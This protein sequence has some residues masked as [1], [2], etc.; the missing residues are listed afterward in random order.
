MTPSVFLIHPPES[1]RLLLPMDARKVA[2][3]GV[4]PPLGILYLA[5]YLNAH[6]DAR[7]DILDA[8]GAG[9]D[10][11]TTVAEV[12][13]RKPS[14][15]GITC[16]TD[17][18]YDICALIQGIK[19][20]SP[21]SHIV[22]G[23]PHL[24]IFARQTLQHPLVDSIVVGD[25]EA[26]LAHLI[27]RLS[28]QT[29][30]PHPGLY[31]KGE[32]TVR[33]DFPVYVEKDLDRLP[34]PE[35]S[36]LPHIYSSAFS[37]GR[38][39][40]MVTSRGCP[41]RCTFCKLNFQKTLLRSARNVVDEMKVIA[42][43]G[44]DEIEIYDDTFGI[45]RDRVLEICHLMRDEGMRFKLT[46][47][48]RAPNLD[49]EVIAA[50]RSV[51]LQRVYLGVETASDA[52][53]KRIRKALKIE[54]VRS[55]V[56]SCKRHGVEVLTYF[57]IGLPGEDESDFR[58]SLELAKDLDPDYANFSVTIPYPGTELYADAVACG[59]LPR[60]FWEDW[61]TNPTPDLQMPVFTEKY[62]RDELL[63]M[64]QKMIRSFYFRP[65]YIARRLKRSLLNPSQFL[66][67]VKTAVSLW[68]G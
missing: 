11:G 32:E 67:D 26:P 16:W 1:R 3:A 4:K 51:G 6:S 59:V 46:I 12:A 45:N 27:R 60:G 9:L 57:M 38:M 62:S 50:L 64:H 40:T 21:N 22:L 65:R 39:T 63:A 19:A 42:G 8:R 13:R 28:R 25:G 20:V 49:D 29:D 2:V 41:F 66:N 47:R 35:R 33:D 31:L 61:V 7:V 55:A 34:F 17:Y 23:G 43:L 18:W 10:I 44:I 68:N 37:Q 36:L 30:E 14:V 24:G 56:A 52:T 54:Q 58:R 53:L 48:D 5:A 15:V